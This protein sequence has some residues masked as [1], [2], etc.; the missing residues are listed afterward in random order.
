MTAQTWL[1]LGGSSSVARAFARLAAQEGADVLLA[2]RDIED[3]RRSAADLRVRG[4]V[5]AR[6]MEFDASALDT[7]DAFV[8]ACKQRTNGR[9]NVFLAFGA[10]P[11]QNAA[12][13][14][15]AKTLEAV[16]VNY[17]GTLSILSRLAPVMEEQE[18]GAIVVLGSVAGDRGRRKNY[19]Y[20]SAKAGVHA[21][22]QGL[23][24][25]LSPKK[26]RVV[27]VKPGFLDTAMTWGLP[28]ILFP[29]SPEAAARA[30]L[31]L[32]RRGPEVAYVPWFWWPVMTA[33]RLLPEPLFKRLNI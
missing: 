5:P 26:V 31:R 28:G 27:T 9:L 29:A 17:V 2:G 33:I 24:A 1:I 32:A 22:V 10:M 4:G 20:G 13:T 3:L 25:R 18:G 19:V 16:R 8:R 30:C 21:Y 14:D 15:F 11:D 6:A 7:H 23:R 12:E